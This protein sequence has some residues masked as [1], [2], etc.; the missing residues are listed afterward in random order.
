MKMTLQGITSSA[1]E[2]GS[3][4]Q[5]TQDMHIVNTMEGQKPLALKIRLV[6]NTAGGQN[7]VE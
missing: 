2:G 4:K 5:V 6:Y 1:V 7:V 3:Q